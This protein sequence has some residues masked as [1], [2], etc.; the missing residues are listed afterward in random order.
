MFSRKGWDYSK[1]KV[2]EIV[3]DLDIKIIDLSNILA[4]KNSEKYFYH[5][6]S[7]FNPSGY[8]FLATEIFLKIN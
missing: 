4:N 8:E 2:M 6:E 7:H 1:R 3:N 5:A